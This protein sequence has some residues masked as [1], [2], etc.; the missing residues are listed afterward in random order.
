MQSVIRL[1]VTILSVLLALSAFAQDKP[2][3]HERAPAASAEATSSSSQPQP[4]RL[5]RSIF[6]G[7][8][9]AFEVH[10]DTEV[11]TGKPVD[12]YMF[13][14]EMQV[15]NSDGDL[16]PEG[17]IR[18]NFFTAKAVDPQVAANPH[19][20]RDCRIWNTLV[21]EAMNHREPKLR[22]WPYV[23][24]TTVLNARIIQTNEDGAVWWSDDI[25]CWGSSDRF[26]AF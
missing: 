11:G 23:E 19:D 10:H 1:A 7:R 8:P 24:F 3:R 17:L 25:E 22:T 16:E 15:M 4:N 14:I 13:A 26:P 20:G 6:D 21:L 5:Y 18:D 9:V 2:I 12:V